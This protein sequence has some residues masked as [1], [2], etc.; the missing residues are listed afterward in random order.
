MQSDT[1]NGNAAT[2][3][4]AT[5]LMVLPTRTPNTSVSS[6]CSRQFTNIPPTTVLLAHRGG[7][8]SPHPV[9]LQGRFGLMGITGYWL[10]SSSHD[11]S[12]IHQIRAPSPVFAQSII[13]SP[14]ALYMEANRSTMA[15]I[16]VETE[17]I[18]ETIRLRLVLFLTYRGLPQAQVG[19]LRAYRAR[20]FT[21][22]SHKSGSG[23]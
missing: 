11:R 6:C 4:P 14:S 10:L 19:G 23:R 2:A 22:P 16:C 13:A 8:L 1:C 20:Y 12:F 17:R 18:R 15:L 9:E 5:P 7:L 21:I 3:T